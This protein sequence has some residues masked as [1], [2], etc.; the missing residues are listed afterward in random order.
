VTTFDTRQFFFSFLLS[1]SQS[2]IPFLFYGLFN[3]RIALADTWSRPTPAN[4][5]LVPSNATRQPARIYLLLTAS[6]QALRV[7]TAESQY[8]WPQLILPNS[9]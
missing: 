9:R 1:S 4:I 7:F 6:R 8:H 2:F 3:F 5:N